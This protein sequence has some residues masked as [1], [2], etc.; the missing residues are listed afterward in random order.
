MMTAQTMNAG[1]QRP[2][3]TMAPTATTPIAAPIVLRSPAGLI[4]RATRSP[5]ASE[6][7]VFCSGYSSASEADVMIHSAAATITGGE[8]SQRG[9][10][11]GSRKR[12]SDVRGFTTPPLDDTVKGAREKGECDTAWQVDQSVLP[13]VE[14]GTLQL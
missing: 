2:S 12:G 11:Q 5:L 10:A 7:S 1:A 13:Y 6:T 3:A 4:P 9:C 8:K 14:T